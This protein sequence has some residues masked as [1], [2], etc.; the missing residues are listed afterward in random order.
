MYKGKIVEIAPSEILFKH[1][2]HPYTQM[3]LS[4]IPKPDPDSEKAKIF[5]SHAKIK[6]DKNAQLKESE[7]NHFVLE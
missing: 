4:A 7:Q 6:L 1:P 2:L 3:L 5:T